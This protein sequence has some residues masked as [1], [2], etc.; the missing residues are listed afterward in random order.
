MAQDFTLPS[1]P[2]LD[3]A[4]VDAT[5]GPDGGFEAMKSALHRSLG[6][7][8]PEELLIAND[9]ADMGYGAGLSGQPGSAMPADV[10]P[11]EWP[12]TKSIRWADSVGRK[13]IVIR[14]QTQEDLDL[15]ERQVL[16]GR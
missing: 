10:A 16:Y 12:F 3:R 6:M 15:L 4:V 9:N 8:S 1:S 7:Q 13:P 2:A 11:Q 14:A 5:Q